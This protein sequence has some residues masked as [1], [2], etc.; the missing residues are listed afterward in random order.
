[1]MALLNSISWVAVSFHTLAAVV[2]ISA[3]LVVFVRNIVHA[4]LWLAICFISLAGV[5]LTLN[6]DFI[7][8]VQIMVYAGAICI[9]VVFGI[10]LI[11]RGNMGETNLFNKQV[12]AGGGVAVLVTVLGGVLS[13]RIRYAGTP[14]AIPENSVENIAT[15]LLSK[16]VVPFEVA[17][18]L[19]LVALVGAIFLAKEVKADADTN[20]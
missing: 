13:F 20:G 14:P 17:A 18:L 7:A 4:V 11:R 5:F 16:Y 3:L 1:M 2:V 12:F 8:M 9:M 19:L 6:A 10:M 15:L